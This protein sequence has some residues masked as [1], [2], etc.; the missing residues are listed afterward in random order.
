MN[1]NQVLA[2]KKDN[3]FTK[4]FNKIKFFF[5]KNKYEKINIQGVQEKK[6]NTG[7]S[8]SLKPSIEYNELI[9]LQ[10]GIEN[11]TVSIADISEEEAE[12]LV[13]LYKNQNPNLK[14]VR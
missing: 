7:F 2:E 4:I 3:I 8:D 13:D 14:L 9:K 12:K 6:I 11:G 5:N 1:K 10:N